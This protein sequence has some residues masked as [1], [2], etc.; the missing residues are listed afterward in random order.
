[1]LAQG[2]P[3]FWSGGN[4]AFSWFRGLSTQA[5]ISC[6]WAETPGPSSDGVRGDPMPLPGIGWVHRE[7]G[8]LSVGPSGLDILNHCSLRCVI[9]QIATAYMV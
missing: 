6:D 3:Q 4:R 7:P 5:G 9:A 2:T 8:D 1:M